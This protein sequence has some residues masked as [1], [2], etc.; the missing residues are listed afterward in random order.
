MILT[1]L[2]IDTMGPLQ[3]QRLTFG[4][5]LNLCR[6][7]APLRGALFQFIG[8]MLYGT[9][10]DKKEFRGTLWLKEGEVTYRLRRSVGPQAESFQFSGGEG[11]VLAAQDLQNL[12]GAPGRASFENQIRLLPLKSAT[13]PD[14]ARELGSFVSSH[15]DTGDRSLHLGKAKQFLKMHRKDYADR[16]ERAG[17]RNIQEK[18]KLKARMEEVDG[19]VQKLKGQEAKAQEAF[20]NEKPAPKAERRR[21]KKSSQKELKALH[22]QKNLMYFLSVLGFFLM[23]SC[24]FLLVLSL[25]KSHGI[26]YWIL[27]GIGLAGGLSLG[28]ETL[29]KARRLMGKVSKVQRSQAQTQREYKRQDE[30]KQKLADRVQEL[31][32]KEKEREADLLNLQEELDRFAL[33]AEKPRGEEAEMEAI[34]LALMR[35]T[36]LSAGMRQKREEAFMERATQVFRD[37]TGGLYDSLLLR[38]GK[39]QVKEGERIIDPERLPRERQEQLYLALQLSARSAENLPLLGEDLFRTYTEEALEE[40]LR[41]FAKQGQQILFY[42]TTTRE[43]DCLEEM[44]IPFERMELSREW[45]ER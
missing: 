1:K 31:R 23:I 19:E 13:G 34:D 7:E 12:L 8:H 43:S 32:Q 14:I 10:R 39:L 4:E 42:V 37:L 20:A 33:D 3:G 26:F 17:K 30:R 9:G 6:G 38:E 16:T 41:Y 24:L 45:A 2:E 22:K 27:L 18:E 35:L 36:D 40:T 5:G 29:L 11:E 21:G 25:G 44:E 28:L 15:L